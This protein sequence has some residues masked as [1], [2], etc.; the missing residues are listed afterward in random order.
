MRV[1]AGSLRGRPLKSPSPAPNGAGLTRPTADRT[2]EG[3]FNVLMHRFQGRGL[4]MVG[5]HVLDAFAGTGALGIEA[6][7]RGAAHATFFDT[8]ATARRVLMENITTLALGACTTCLAVDARQP[9]AAPRPMDV[10]FLDPPYAAGLAGGLIVDTL[11]AL[12]TQGWLT[13]TSL[14][15]AEMA[16]AENFPLGQ[17]WTMV[18]ERVY[19][20]ARVVFLTIKTITN[21]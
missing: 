15:V 11:A 16:K 13:D 3:V 9:P 10:I 1:I 7:S 18:D 5:A 20:Q 19:G 17:H 4:Q 2:R 14:V 12:Q 8:N 21:K 6:L